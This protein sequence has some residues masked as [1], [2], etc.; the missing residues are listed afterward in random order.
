MSG[1]IEIDSAALR[2][3]ARDLGEAGDRLAAIAAD[4]GS[5][6]ISA[7]AFGTMNSYLGGPVAVAAR[8]TTD[9]IRETGAVVTALGASAQAA[10]DDFAAYEDDVTRTLTAAQ[11]DLDGARELR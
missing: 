3:A 7:G 9:L 10:A 1:D 8:H 6:G 11:A 4:A 2:G 5:V